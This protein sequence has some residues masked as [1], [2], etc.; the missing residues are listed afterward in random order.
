ML[1]PPPSVLQDQLENSSNSTSVDVFGNHLSSSASF[2]SNVLAY[3][4][5]ISEPSSAAT[6]FKLPTTVSKSSTLKS[7]MDCPKTQLLDP[8]KFDKLSSFKTNNSNSQLDDTENNNTDEPRTLED[9]LYK[10]WNLGA[11]LMNE[12]SDSFDVLKLLNLLDTCQKENRELEK[13]LDELKK[14]SEHLVDVHDKLSTPYTPHSQQNQH[15]L[16][17]QHHQQQQHF[18]PPNQIHSMQAQHISNNSPAKSKQNLALAASPISSSSSSPNQSLLN[19]NNSYLMSQMSPMGQQAGANSAS[20]NS[21]V[22]NLSSILNSSSIMQSLYQSNGL[23]SFLNSSLTDTL[24]RAA[25]MPAPSPAN[26]SMLM[27]QQLQQQQQQQHQMMSLPKPLASSGS[28]ASSTNPQTGASNLALNQSMIQSFNYQQQLA[29][30]LAS[31]TG[32][33]GVAPAD[34]SS[35]L[36]LLNTT[37]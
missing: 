35:S 19:L 23:K 34:S 18:Y 16:L 5:A 8:K 30:Y 36:Q 1:T 32:A 10:Q 33:A 20:A 21:L 29:M 11:E 26:A 14:Q 24:S 25:G 27:Q 17:Q 13:K 7:L 3:K 2:S 22:S 28:P 4:S 31:S 37:K 12:Q 15:H 9:L 6:E